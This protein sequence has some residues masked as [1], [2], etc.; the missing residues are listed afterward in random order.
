MGLGLY[1]VSSENGINEAAAM[2]KGRKVAELEGT[3][4]WWLLKLTY[5]FVSGGRGGDSRSINPGW[6]GR[7][8]EI[9]LQQT[10]QPDMLILG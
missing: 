9:D 6:W 5:T 4:W 7:S 10:P 3:L 2:G 8:R 1:P